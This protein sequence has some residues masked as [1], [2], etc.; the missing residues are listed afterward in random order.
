[1]YER[2][3]FLIRAVTN[4]IDGNLLLLIENNKLTNIEL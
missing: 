2:K 1:M 4:N 3:C